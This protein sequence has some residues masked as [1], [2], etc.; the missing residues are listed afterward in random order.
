[1][2]VKLIKMPYKHHHDKKK[3]YRLLVIA[4][5][6]HGADNRRLLFP[7][8]KMEIERVNNPGLLWQN[9]GYKY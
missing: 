2:T 4:G 3:Y 9:Q 6:D 5:V 8:P 7:I 1:M